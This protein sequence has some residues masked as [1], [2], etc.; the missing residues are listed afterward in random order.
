[1]PTSSKPQR[2]CSARDAV[3]AG[4][5]AG[6]HD[7]EAGL[8]RRPRPAAE[9]QPGRCPGP[10]WSRCDVHRVLDRRAVRGPL[11]VR[12]QRGEPDHR[13]CR[14]D[15]DDR[16]E[17][18]RAGRQPRRWSSRRAR[19]EVERGRRRH[20]PRGCRSSRIASASAASA[21]RI[22][23]RHGAAGQRACHAGT[24]SRPARPGRSRDRHPD[25]PLHSCAGRGS[26]AC[27]ARPLSSVGRAQPW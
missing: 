21:R 6:H 20:R 25:G 11:L 9:Q 8:A 13:R 24:L 27:R 12:R 14:V 3:A 5:D 22:G 26:A 18:A 19:H 23:R 1:M 10:W 7:V 2:A 16:R 15:G 4:L 17:G